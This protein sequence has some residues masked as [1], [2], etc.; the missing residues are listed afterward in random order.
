MMP[1][2]VDSG[3]LSTENSNIKIS[4]ILSIPPILSMSDEN[5][6]SLSI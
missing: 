1:T 6:Y 3:S 4:L 2:G 5:L